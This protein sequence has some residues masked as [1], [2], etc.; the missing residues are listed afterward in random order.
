MFLYGETAFSF[1]EKRKSSFPIPLPK[2][3]TEPRIKKFLNINF[4]R[5]HSHKKYTENTKKRLYKFINICYNYNV[6]IL[7]KELMLMF[8]KNLSIVVLIL[9][10][11]SACTPTEITD[12]D[13]QDIIE[14]NNVIEENDTSVDITESDQPVSPEEPD[15]TEPDISEPVEPTI[16]YQEIIDNYLSEDIVYYTVKANTLYREDSEKT[17][18][19][20]ED[21]T[22][23]DMGKITDEI[24]A[25]TA[26][27]IGCDTTDENYKFLLAD[28]KVSYAI[29]NGKLY[30]YF[31]EE[32]YLEVIYENEKLGYAQFY[33]NKCVTVALYSQRYLDFFDSMVSMG[34]NTWKEI[35]DADQYY[36]GE[37]FDTIITVDIIT[38]E[39]TLLEGRK[40]VLGDPYSTTDGDF[41][42]VYTIE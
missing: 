13:P 12:G 16:N 41:A 9:L 27:A 37:M 28:Y 3:K 10:L 8:L 29:Y 6:V 36:S 2:K 25:E 17:R 40:D 33:T 23:E 15:V 18:C 35:Y 42:G 38:G 1:R 39:E 34:Y 24:L 26:T 4:E 19:Y 14:N 5:M 7:L 20:P 21:A 31:Y 30:R 11:L 22:V 32:D